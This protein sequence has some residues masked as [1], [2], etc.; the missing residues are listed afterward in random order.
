[1]VRQDAEV[2]A[3]NHGSELSIFFPQPQTQPL[4]GGVFSDARG[5]AVFYVLW[6][7]SH[8]LWLD[9]GDDNIAAITADHKGDIDLTD[10]RDKETRIK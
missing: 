2:T 3:W 5:G 4:P 9:E 6:R 10:I 1:M 8:L 7:F